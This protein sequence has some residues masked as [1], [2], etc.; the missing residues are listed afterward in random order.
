MPILFS[1]LTQ[2]GQDEPYVVLYILLNFQEIIWNVVVCFFHFSS[3]NR[4][5]MVSLQNLLQNRTADRPRGC[6]YSKEELHI[7]MKV[8]K[9]TYRR[10]HRGTF[11]R[12]Q[13]TLG[14]WRSSRSYR[15]QC[16]W[17]NS[18]GTVYHRYKTPASMHSFLLLNLHIWCTCHGN[19]SF[20]AS[21]ALWRIYSGLTRNLVRNV[22]IILLCYKLM[23]Q[24]KL[25]LRS[26]NSTRWRHCN[27]KLFNCG[28]DA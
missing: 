23:P 20:V 5:M 7:E 27:K 22:Q 18:S 12:H 25:I 6:S 21:Q 19:S 4:W 11:P 2:M 28:T 26:S 16:S 14:C 24:T 3:I 9:K 1:H 8:Q 17:S 13:G 10:Y 15:H